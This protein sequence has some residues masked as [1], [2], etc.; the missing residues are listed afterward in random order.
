M[1]TKQAVSFTVYFWFL[2]KH[3]LIINEFGIVQQ[4]MTFKVFNDSKRL[5]DPSQYFNLLEGKNIS[6]MLPRSW[7]KSFDNG[8]K[9][10][11]KMRRC[12]EC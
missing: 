11:T 12:N 3:V 9:I 2:K 7:R 4:H 1:I 8:M 6:A 5:L 10:P